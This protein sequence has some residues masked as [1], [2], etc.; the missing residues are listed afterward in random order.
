MLEDL[1]KF[2]NNKKILL[3]NENLL[4]IEKNLNYLQNSIKKILNIETNMNE[5]KK[6]NNLI[7]DNKKDK[8]KMKKLQQLISP[9]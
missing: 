9:K 1:E 8:M 4:E 5:E 2:K 7:L 3:L 6:N